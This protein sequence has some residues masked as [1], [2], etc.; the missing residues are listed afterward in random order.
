VIFCGRTTPVSRTG[1]PDDE[2]ASHADLLRD[3]SGTAGIGDE[4]R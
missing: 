4:Q 3:R 1:T 2:Q